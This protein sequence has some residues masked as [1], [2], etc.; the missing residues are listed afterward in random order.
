MFFLEVD[1]QLMEAKES[2]DL[3]LQAGEW[4]KPVVEFSLS[5]KGPEYW[6]AGGESPD[7]C[8]PTQE[9]GAP[10]SKDKRKWISRH[11]QRRQI[12][13]SFIFLFC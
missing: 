1:S 8:T 7:L 2:H 13:P 3:H 11:K 12:C 10:V 9:P 4:G 6:G 5:P